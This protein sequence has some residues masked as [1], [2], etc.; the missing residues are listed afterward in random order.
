MS[1]DAAGP[2]LPANTALHIGSAAYRAHRVYANPPQ[3]S[4]FCVTFTR[5]SVT[6]CETPQDQSDEA[7]NR[8]Q[9][10]LE[11]AGDNLVRVSG[12]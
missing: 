12:L 6:W 1:G 2:L 7:E 10:R 11:R 5:A 4:P 9:G 3:I 8:K